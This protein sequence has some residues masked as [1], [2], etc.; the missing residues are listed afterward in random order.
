[1]KSVKFFFLVC[2]L[3]AFRSGYAQTDVDG[4]MMAKRNLC[5]GFIYG[6]TAWNHYWEGT[7]LRVNA[8][9]GNVTSNS[10]AAM[11]NTIFLLTKTQMEPIPFRVLLTLWPTR[12]FHFQILMR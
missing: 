6:Y 9:I 10:V 11:T 12:F 8:N 1:M 4:L 5:G 7:R 2:L 3:L